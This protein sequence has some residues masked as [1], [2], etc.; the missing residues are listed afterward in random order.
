METVIVAIVVVLAVGFLCRYI[1]RAWKNEDAACGCSGCGL[2]GKGDSPCN[3]GQG[4]F[5]DGN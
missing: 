1:Y 2:C 4:P 3:K 5:L